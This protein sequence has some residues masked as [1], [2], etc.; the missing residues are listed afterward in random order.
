MVPLDRASICELNL[1][2]S[3]A[4]S[5]AVCDTSINFHIDVP[6]QFPLILWSLNQIVTSRWVVTG[7]FIIAFRTICTIALVSL[8]QDRIERFC[9]DVLV[10]EPGD[11]LRHD[12]FHP[13]YWVGCLARFVKVSWHR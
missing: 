3:I 6:I 7:L 12:K 4:F 11:T 13:F 8:S 9:K 5:S 10:G 2:E 1:L